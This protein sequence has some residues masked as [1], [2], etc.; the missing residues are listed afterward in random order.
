LLGRLS[1]RI[2]C[3][4]FG[5]GLIPPLVRMYPRYYVSCAQKMDLVA[6]IFS[7]AS[8]NLMKTCFNLSR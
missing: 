4:F 2:S 7:L 3:T 5:C 8:C 1:A 6:L